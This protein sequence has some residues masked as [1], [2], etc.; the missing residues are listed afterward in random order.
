M[1]ERR[2]MSSRAGAI[3]LTREE[4][5]R[6]AA[7]RARLRAKTVGWDFTMAIAAYAILTAVIILR[8]EGF[9]TEFVAPIA[10]LGLAMILFIHKRRGEQL[11]ERYYAEELL[12]LQE[13]S[14]GEKAEVLIPSPL[15]PRE[16]EV[17]DYVALGCLN[18]QIADKLGISE[19]TIKNHISSILRKLDANDR[20]QAVVMAIR[21]GWISPQVGEP[22]ES[23]PRR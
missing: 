23:P 10:I 5:E 7:K 17:I 1:D 14:Q 9:G 2:E 16:T 11:F 19:Q 21:Y 22:S 8:F 13:H 15:T 6:L 12:E 20:T 18:K 3:N 4:I